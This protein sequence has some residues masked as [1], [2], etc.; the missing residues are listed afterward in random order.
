MNTRTVNTASYFAGI[1]R[2]KPFASLDANQFENL[3]FLSTI[4]WT[5]SIKTYFADIGRRIPFFFYFYFY[6]YLFWQ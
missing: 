6:F 5:V 4:T 2:R 3:F 1:G